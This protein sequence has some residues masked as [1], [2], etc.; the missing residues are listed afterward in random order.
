MYRNVPVSIFNFNCST[1]ELSSA[2]DRVIN[3]SE[4]PDNLLFFFS[5]TVSLFW[6]TILRWT[7]D[8]IEN[9]V[10]YAVA[11]NRRQISSWLIAGRL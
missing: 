4:L 5:F 2:A 1:R 9:H 6:P 10:I 8:R 11:C 3:K 7:L